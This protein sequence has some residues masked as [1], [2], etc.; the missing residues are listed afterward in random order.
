MNDYVMV[1]AYNNQICQLPITGV[2]KKKLKHK[3]LMGIAMAYQVWRYVRD[4]NLL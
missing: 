2:V 3:A 4:Y 1:F